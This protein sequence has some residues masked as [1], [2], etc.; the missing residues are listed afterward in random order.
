M[1]ESQRYPREWLDQV[2]AVV[3]ACM[4]PGEL[5]IIVHPSAGLADGGAPQDVPAALVP[6]DLW[7]PNTPLWVQLGDDMRVIRVWRREVV[8]AIPP[9][10]HTG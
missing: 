2:P 5:R 8:P 3:F 6:F 9:A 4:R 10:A 7:V 1:A